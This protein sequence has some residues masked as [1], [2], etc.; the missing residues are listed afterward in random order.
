MHCQEPIGALRLDAFTGQGPNAG[1][2]IN[3]QMQL[4]SHLAGRL[5]L[6]R[7]GIALSSVEG[8]DLSRFRV[9][10]QASV[11]RSLMLGNG[12]AGCA[13]TADRTAA[14]ARLAFLPNRLNWRCP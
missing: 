2:W 6:V 12:L 10:G 5:V 11:Y 14:V 13:F 1:L 4:S 8:S 9:Q 3:L 7:F